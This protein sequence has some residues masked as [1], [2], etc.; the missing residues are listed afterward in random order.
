MSTRC[1]HDISGSISQLQNT[2]NRW[3][4]AQAKVAEQWSDQTAQ[5]FQ[6]E[7][8]QSVEPLL[9]RALAALQE[10]NELVRSL[11]KRVQ[12]TILD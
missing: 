7:N 5:R 4:E 8:L 10:A 11:E 3:R 2:L 9:G 1:R 6:E 12:D